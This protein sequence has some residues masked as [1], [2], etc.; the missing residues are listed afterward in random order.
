MA[1]RDNYIRRLKEHTDLGQVLVSIDESGFDERVRPVYG[2]AMKGQQAITYHPHVYVSKHKRTSLLMAIGSDGSR[3]HGLFNE[4]TKGEDFADFILG[5]PFPPGS[6]IILDNH[7]IHDV[8]CVQ[9]AMAVNDYH[10]LFIP[11]QSPEFNPIEMVFGTLKNDFYRFRHSALFTTVDDAVS[12]LLE[13]HGR[14]EQIKKYFRHVEDFVSTLTDDKTDLNK[15]LIDHICKGET[16]F[17]NADSERRWNGAKTLKHV[18]S[19]QLKAADKTIY[20]DWSRPV[21]RFF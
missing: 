7:S 10:P 14:P 2:Y 21:E 6:A 18:I 12:M 13:K 15:E 8:E 4:T 9:V 1:R 16:R 17:P 11:P 20:G 19:K 5:L 3:M